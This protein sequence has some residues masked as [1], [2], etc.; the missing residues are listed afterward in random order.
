MDHLQTEARNPASTELDELS[1]LQFV[2]LMN[3][4]DARVIP[5]VASQAEAIARA[6]EVISE[7]LQ[8]GGRLIY[9]G[10]GT[11]GRL[12]VLDASECPPTFNAPPGL[13]VGVIAGG[14][15]AL[16]RSVEGAEDHPEFALN[17][18][19]AVSLSCRDVLVGIATSGRTPYVLAAV[20]HA[21]QLGAFTIGLS[22]NSDADII[23]RVDLAIT[24]VVGPEVLSGSTRLKAGTATKLVLNMLTTGVMVQ[25]GKTYGNLMVDL[26]AT[27]EKLRNRTN[28]IVREATGLDRDA[29][30]TLLENCNNELKTA[31]VSHLASVSAAEARERLQKANG[32]VRAAVG[33]NGNGNGHGRVSHA[34]GNGNGK[35][36]EELVLGID[37]GGTRTV[38]MLA[39]RRSG[40]EWKLLGRGEAGPSNRQAVG[41]P[42]ALAALDEAVERAFISAARSRCEVRAACLGL[43]GAG[44]A[45][46]QAVVR[47]WAARANLADEVQVIEDAAL[48]LAAGTPKGWGVAVVAGTGS[49]AFARAADG[50]TARA[51]GWGPLL[52]DEGS[53]YAI[54]LAGLRAAARS[55][56]GRAQPTPLTDRLL[57]AYGL[58]RPEELIGVV[59]RG[60]DRAALASLGPV[61]LEAAEDGD[62]VAEEIVR[63]A[64]CE[65]ASA[66]AAA[67][68]QLNLRGA[69]PVAL[70]GGLLVASPAYRERFLV[71]LTARGLNAGPV[72]LVTEPAEG[73]VRL[74]LDKIASHS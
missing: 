71:A 24:P 36:P 33:A 45:A 29:A 50:R 72:T 22:C 52:G 10:A 28:R 37:G 70:A 48:L 39:T 59:Y 55:A 18:L 40:T 20:D 73:A 5:A 25:L 65:L 13:V 57:A 38:V 9:V 27:N 46:D 19:A 21:R 68:R 67:A 23:P 44:R 61:V 74:A 1:T 17:D 16:T 42:A 4:E 47:E 41:T 66:A 34:N 58:T 51:G 49:M 35:T 12:G 30:E 63:E 31:L 2:R 53:G 62:P 69:F 60:G 43:A 26:R 11:S 6:V 15:T 54:A 32:R 3:A 64:A 7:R 56:D 8:T 14:P